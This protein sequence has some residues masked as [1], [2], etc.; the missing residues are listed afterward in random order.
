MR[1][2]KV[3]SSASVQ[4]ATA[5]ASASTWSGSRETVL[6]RIKRP[7]HTRLVATRVHLPGLQYRRPRRS[8]SRIGQ[9]CAKKSLRAVGAPAPQ[10]SA[11]A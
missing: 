7:T 5:A 3:A 9:T 10:L 4:G 1:P 2:M 8:A 6:F 11:L